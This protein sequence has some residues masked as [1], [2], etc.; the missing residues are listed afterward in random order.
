MGT[1]GTD[2]FDNDLSA[3]MRMDY[4]EQV[5]EGVPGPEIRANLLEGYA[6]ALAD[7]DDAP[8]F[9]MTLAALQLKYGH[10]EASVREQALAAIAAGSNLRRW[11]AEAGP[12][13]AAKRRA[14]LEALRDQLQKA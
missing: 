13:D 12:E 1:W 11:E 5:E 2:I 9:W 4:T 8:L 14:V 6:E 10:L 3:D 7:E